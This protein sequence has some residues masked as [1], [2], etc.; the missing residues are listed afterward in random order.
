MQLRSQVASAALAFR[1][2]NPSG[3]LSCVEIA[4]SAVAVHDIE[5]AASVPHAY[6]DTN[7][8]E[9]RCSTAL[10]VVHDEVMRPAQN[11]PSETVS[12]ANEGAPTILKTL[13]THRVVCN[14]ADEKDFQTTGCWAAAARRRTVRSERKR[15]NRTFCSGKGPVGLVALVHNSAGWVPRL[16]SLRCRCAAT[17][18][19][20]CRA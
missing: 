16:T 3:L 1:N 8:V 18:D 13:R 12:S 5:P 7:G 9:P 20:A 19:K 6:S 10:A 17:P 4:R 14:V 11:A 2:A 15:G